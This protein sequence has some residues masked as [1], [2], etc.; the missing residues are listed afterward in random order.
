MGLRVHVRQEF[1]GK[2][3]R[4]NGKEFAGKVWGLGFTFARSLPAKYYGRLRSDLG[5]CACSKSR[6]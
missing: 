5:S 4:M 3:L 1:A 2:V 6:V